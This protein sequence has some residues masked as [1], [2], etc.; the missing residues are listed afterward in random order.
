MRLVFDARENVYICAFN[1]FGKNTVTVGTNNA[2]KDTA[3]A[4]NTT[5]QTPR[6]DENQQ[7]KLFNDSDSGIMNDANNSG[8]Q[9]E[10]FL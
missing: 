2:N 7:E 8:K 9:Q 6:K 4:P 10:L 3:D 5:S 1:T